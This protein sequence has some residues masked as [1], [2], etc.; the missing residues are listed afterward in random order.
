MGTRLLSY[1]KP[2]TPSIEDI[3]TDVLTAGNS[4]EVLANL[5]IVEEF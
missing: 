5:T 2:K 4:F 3:T 1:L